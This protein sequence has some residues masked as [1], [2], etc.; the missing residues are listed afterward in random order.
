MNIKYLLLLILYPYVVYG[1]FYDR[2][3]EGWFW[4]EKSKK[5]ELTIEEESQSLTPQQASRI[6]QQEQAQLKSLLDLAV[7]Q[8]T[9]KNIR[10]YM[11]MQ[12]KIVNRAKSFSDYWSVVVYTNRELD[13]EVSFPTSHLARGLY[14]DEELENHTKA[15]KNLSKTYGLFYFFSGNCKYCHNFAPIVKSF[16]EKYGWTVFAVSLDGGSLLEFPDAKLNNG[17]AE[18]FQVQGTPTLIA[19]DPIT[20]EVIPIAYNITSEAELERRIYRILMMSKKNTFE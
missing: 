14:Q 20:R 19:V 10:N 17:I 12:Q 5:E 16:A 7:V 4:Y 2:H 3:A 6:L 15:I 1:G 18:A 8:P 9:P 13:S 11:V